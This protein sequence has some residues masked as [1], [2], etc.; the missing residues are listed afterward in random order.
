MGDWED[1]FGMDR[2]VESVINEIDHWNRK[3]ERQK[4]K[5]HQPPPHVD[6]DDDVLPSPRQSSKMLRDTGGSIQG[7]RTFSSFQDALA[8]AK[9]NPGRA[10]TRI[11]GR[12]GFMVVE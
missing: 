6:F 7:A 4:R 9:A 8:W 2:S 10:I 12:D 5:P 1:I 11:P 3:E